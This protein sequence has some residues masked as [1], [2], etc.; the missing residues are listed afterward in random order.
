M[1]PKGA[2][3]EFRTEKELVFCMDNKYV[4]QNFNNMENNIRLTGYS[5]DSVILHK[6]ILGEVQCLYV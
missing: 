6:K 3:L 5:N 1:Y 2:L 4:S